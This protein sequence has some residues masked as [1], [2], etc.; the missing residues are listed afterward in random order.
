MIPPRPI[1][2]DGLT[3]TMGGNPK[4]KPRGRAIPGRR[5]PV[6]LTGG[7]KR[8]ASALTARACVAVLD[9]GGA[10]AIRAAW[11]GLAIR[12][13]II[14]TFSTAKAERWGAPHTHKPDKDNIEKMILDCLAKAG[15]LGGDD[16]RVADGATRK[17]W[18]RA[19]S[20]AVT[21]KPM[22]NTTRPSAGPATQL[23]PEWLR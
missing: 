2:I 10:D 11:G 20:M 14:A 18:G 17:V 15:A 1:I 22:S 12:V 19:G 21:V 23:T 16:A 7:A 13:D 5:R 9:L 6:S 4:A 3:M 8:Y